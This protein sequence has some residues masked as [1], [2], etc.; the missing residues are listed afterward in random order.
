M[1]QDR[2]PNRDNSIWVDV[3]SMEYPRMLYKEDAINLEMQIENEFAYTVT[4]CV[5]G[6]TLNER[7]VSCEGLSILMGTRR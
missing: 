2:S 7:C 5:H 6:R 1:P 3:L 4:A